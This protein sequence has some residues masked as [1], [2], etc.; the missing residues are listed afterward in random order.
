MG[1]NRKGEKMKM[2]VT[3]RQEAAEILAGHW[4]GVGSV[5]YRGATYHRINA[6]FS[7]FGRKQKD[8][9]YDISKFGAEKYIKFNQNETPNKTPEAGWR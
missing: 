4:G 7:A 6:V 1:H 9:S 2:H 5:E 3:N 8:G